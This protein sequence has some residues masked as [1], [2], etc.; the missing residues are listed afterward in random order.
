MV[1]KVDSPRLAKRT[2]CYECSKEIAEVRVIVGG[3][4]FQIARIDTNPHE[5]GEVHLLRD[6]YRA[7]RRSAIHEGIRELH[8][9]FIFPYHRCIKAVGGGHESKS[10]KTLLGSPEP[11]TER[12]EQRERARQL[13]LALERAKR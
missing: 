11:G 10:L 5:N 13:K 9:P 8:K 7:F 6:G 4:T 1:L 2:T 12:Y 3:Q